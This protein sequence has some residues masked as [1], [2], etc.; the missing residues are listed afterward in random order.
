MASIC[1]TPKWVVISF[2]SMYMLV[3]FYYLRLMLQM[4]LSWLVL[5]LPSIPYRRHAN[6][7]ELAQGKCFVISEQL[8]G[9][10]RK[11]SKFLLNSS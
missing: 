3:S 9:G 10:I 7:T 8:L 6:A 5:V 11:R 4:P 2:V 1:S